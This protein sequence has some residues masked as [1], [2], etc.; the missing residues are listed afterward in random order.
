MNR[1]LKPLALG[2]LALGL[3]ACAPHG[4]PPAPAVTVTVTPTPAPPVSDSNSPDQ[5]TSG[6]RRT[7]EAVGTTTRELWEDTKEFGRGFWD[8]FTEDGE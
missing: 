8:A 2:A 7:G 4:E 6:S 5:G 1:L 3:T